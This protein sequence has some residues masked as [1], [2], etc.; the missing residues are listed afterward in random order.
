MF[1]CVATRNEMTSLTDFGKCTWQAV[2]ILRRRAS[3]SCRSPCKGQTLT[4]VSGPELAFFYFKLNVYVQPITEFFKIK[5]KIQ[6]F[7]KILASTII[8]SIK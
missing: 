1:E 4:L 2:F 7:S 5:K 3:Y 6:I 8:L